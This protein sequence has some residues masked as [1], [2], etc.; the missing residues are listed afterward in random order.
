MRMQ[1]K[2]TLPVVSL[3]LFAGITWNSVIA[4]SQFRRIPNRYFWWASFRLDADPLN[5]HPSIAS[6]CEAGT[7]NCGRWDLRAIYVDP[8]LL[9]EA[10]IWLSLPTF[11]VTTVVVFGLGRL[12]VNEIWSFMVATPPLLFA[13]YYFIGM[14]VDHTRHM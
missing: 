3:I 10:F 11:A 5:K 14:M 6:P 8:G 4:N 13:W 2:Y 9:V 1:W 7:G 12:G